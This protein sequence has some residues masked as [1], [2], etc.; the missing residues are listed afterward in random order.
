MRPLK[1]YRLSTP[2]DLK[3]PGA[4]E[5]YDEDRDHRAEEHHE[6]QP[7]QPQQP[8]LA[9]AL[10]WCR[11]LRDQ[12]QH[13]SPEV[14]L[15]VAVVVDQEESWDL[16]RRRRQQPEGQRDSQSDQSEQHAVWPDRGWLRQRRVDHLKHRYLLTVVARQL[17][18]RVL[19][20]HQPIVSH[21]QTIVFGLRLIE[22]AGGGGLPRRF[23]GH[24]VQAPRFAAHV[25]PRNLN[26][27]FEALQ[28]APHHAKF[29]RFGRRRVGGLASVR[30]TDCFKPRDLLIDRDQ[31][32]PRLDHLGILLRGECCEIFD[33]P[34][35]LGPARQQDAVSAVR[36]K[37][38][39]IRGGLDQLLLFGDLPLLL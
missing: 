35:D 32:S 5:R 3:N 33:L 37:P 16:Q 25:A 1:T 21:Y 27:G 4:V 38:A 36:R 29:T 31:L 13:G 9:A 15:D 19:L 2:Q 12:R 10:D 8:P 28:F 18:Q 30:S 20:I 24:R 34:F 23:A 26:F 6:P 11:R 22:P 14:I 7:A 39:R 17:L